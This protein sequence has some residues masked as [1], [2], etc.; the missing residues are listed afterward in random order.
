MDTEYRVTLDS[1][2]FFEA[3]VHDEGCI[4]ICADFGNFERHEVYLSKK[5]AA[6]LRDFL[7]QLDLGNHD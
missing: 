1:D 6:K 7:I 4:L 2:G 3:M 5:E